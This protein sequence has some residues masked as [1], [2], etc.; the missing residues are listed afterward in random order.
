MKKVLSIIAVFAFV[1][2][3]ANAQCSVYSSAT[4]SI[5]ASIFSVRDN[6]GYDVSINGTSQGLYAMSKDHFI[7]RLWPRR[8]RKKK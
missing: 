5:S 8:P 1:A 2:N 6:T 7:S 3:N 4:S